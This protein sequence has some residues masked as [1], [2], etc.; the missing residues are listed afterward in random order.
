MSLAASALWAPETPPPTPAAPPCK[1]SDVCF[2]GMD[3]DKG[4]RPCQLSPSSP[5]ASGDSPSHSCHASLRE[6]S[7]HAGWTLR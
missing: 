3:S 4:L 5:L 7:R 6:V 1:A 2:T